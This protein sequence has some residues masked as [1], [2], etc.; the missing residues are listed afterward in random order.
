METPSLDAFLDEFTAL[1][2]RKKAVLKLL[3]EAYT[4]GVPGIITKFHDRQISFVWTI[5]LP[6]RNA[7][8]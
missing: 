8:P 6:H 4:Y 5:Y 2:K 7:R 3:R 1:P